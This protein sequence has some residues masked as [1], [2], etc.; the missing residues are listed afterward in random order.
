MSEEAYDGTTIALS[1]ALFSVSAYLLVKTA[2]PRNYVV[3]RRNSKDSSP[4]THVVS[5]PFWAST[6]T[7]IGRYVGVEK[8]ERID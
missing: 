6:A 8:V 2:T 1:F 5:V 3:T 7:E 4:I